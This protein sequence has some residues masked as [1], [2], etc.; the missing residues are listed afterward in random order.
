MQEVCMSK[1]SFIKGAAILAAAGLISKFI[2][3]LF[4][5]PL[6]NLIGS[7]GIGY[8]QKAYPIYSFLL[9][10]STAGIPTAISKL[11]A[12]NLALRNYRDAHKVFQLSV[13][14]ML[15]IGLST[16]IVF[17]SGSRLIAKLTGSEGAFYSI[18]AIAPSLIFVTLISSFRGYFQGMQYMTPT[19]LSQ[20][21]EQTGKLILG[22]WFASMFID[23]GP[24]YSAAAAVAGVTLSEGA[25]LV[26]LMGMYRNK[27]KEIIHNIRSSPRPRTSLS[28]RSILS[29]LII[30]AFPITIGSSIMP[31]VNVADTLIVGNRLADAGFNEIEANSLFGLLTGTAN[32]LINFP[33]VLTIALAMSLV[34]AI[35]ESYANKDY[36]GIAQKTSTGIRLT[37]LLGMPAAAGMA[38]LARPI[39]ALLYGGLPESEITV[40]GEILSILAVG[41]IFLTLVQ[42]LTA[43]LQGLS[44]MT[45]PVKNLAIGAL[46]KIVITYFLVAN[47]DINVKGAA[48]GTVVCYGIAAVLD[49]AAVVR[50]SRTPV[51]F[52]D[53]IVK[54]VIAVSIMSIA[55]FF[56]NKYFITMVSGNKATLLSILV[57]V[58]IYAI[59]LLATGAVNKRDLELMPGGRKLGRILL[60]LKL[61]RE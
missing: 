1:K 41:V 29:R 4:R 47:P 10:I 39:C 32:P 36:K 17:S 31:L 21:I 19:A 43:I 30:I 38:V 6:T 2:G 48:I 14:L 60:K 42:T 40:A 54:P 59:V 23:K 50:Y 11:V 51:P 8:Y 5:I 16:F 18:L 26:L 37:L 28:N 53:F 3:A 55:V 24:E 33:A 52:M 20:I 7:V 56:A 27:R 46:F 58:I 13:R 45:V 34:P 57:G 49:M 35:S 44:K 9:I 12:E 22:L 25:A 15:I 61:I